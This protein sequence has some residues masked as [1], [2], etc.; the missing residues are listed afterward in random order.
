MHEAA[1]DRARAGVQVLVGAP[2]GEIDLPVVKPQ[3]H[4]AHGMGEV[5]SDAAAVPPGYGRDPFHIKDLARQI[6]DSAHQDQ[7]N[8]AAVPLDQRLDVLQ[9]D[10]ILAGPWPGDQERPGGVKA[11]VPDVGPHG[12]TVRREGA[13]LKED[14]VARRGGAVEGRQHQVKVHG[15]SVHHD[16]LARQSAHQPGPGLP[17][18]LV[19]AVPG[20]LV[21]EVRVDAETLPGGDFRLDQRSRRPRREPQGIA[22]EVDDRLTVGAGRDVEQGATGRE[23]VV[24][25]ELQ[26]E[27]FLGAPLAPGRHTKDARCR[28]RNSR[29][30]PASNASRVS[31]RSSGR[32]SIS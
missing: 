13:A 27:G 18:E 1:R 4:V 2:D 3:G 25:V 8:L 10:Q 21:F 23:P 24:A 32:D 12:V 6:V 7:R 19:V 20:R 15:E 5:E 28:P 11:V 14:P 29:A 26:R 9:T 16:D 30:V 17:E 31:G 22:A